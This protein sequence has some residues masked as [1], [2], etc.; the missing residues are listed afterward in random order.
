MTERIDHVDEAIG[1]RE[2]AGDVSES[3]AALLLAA[4]QIHA[5]LALV[6]QTRI[7]NIIALDESWRGE[8]GDTLMRLIRDETGRI[9]GNEINPEIAEALGINNDEGDD[10]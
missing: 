7:A 5:V 8:T 6:E 1:Y 2:A 9:I 3:G 10:K 4:G